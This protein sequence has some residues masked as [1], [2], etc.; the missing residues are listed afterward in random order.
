M[1]VVIVRAWMLCHGSY[2]RSGMDCWDSWEWMHE[3]NGL[4]Y[5]SGMDA[6][7]SSGCT[8]DMDFVNVRKALGRGWTGGVD[9]IVDRTCILLVLDA[10]VAW[11][12][13]LVNDVRRSRMCI[14]R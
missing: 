1:D 10:P 11:M 9:V 7:G 8:G 12:L 4:L 13:S 14:F 6:V 5:R 3:W 2:R